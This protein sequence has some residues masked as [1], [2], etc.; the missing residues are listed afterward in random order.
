NAIAGGPVSGAIE[1]VA[2]HPNQPGTVFVG[3]VNGGIWRTSN[4][5]P[6]TTPTWTPLTDQFPS[7][8][9]GAIAF[10]PAD[11][12]VLYAWAGQPS[13]RRR[14]SLPQHEPGQYLDTD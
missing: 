5:T 9:I 4:A 12:H 14:G 8:S 2:V 11:V 6:G 10:A 7:L 13:S 1:V 3:S